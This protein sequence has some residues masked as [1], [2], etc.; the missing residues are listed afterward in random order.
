M[1]SKMK[2]E[3]IIKRVLFF[4][5]VLGA[6]LRIPNIFN[7]LPY[8][9]QIDEGIVNNIVLNLNISDLNPHDY[10]YPGLIYYILFPVFA[11]FKLFLLP[12]IMHV[13][14]MGEFSSY[15]LIGRALI[16]VFGISGII[17]IYAA[18]KEL[19][20]SYTGLIAALFLAIDPMCIAWS[21]ILKPDMLM[22]LLV[23]TAFL[24]ICRLYNAKNAGKT[25]YVLA[26][27]FIGLAVA[28]KYN[29][30]LI[31]VPF[32]AV[33][34]LKQE[35]RADFINKNLF[36]ALFFICFAFFLFNPFIVLDFSTFLKHIKSE[37]NTATWGFNLNPM[38]NRQG[39]VNYPL[40]LV[41]TLGSG[42]L[43]L[44]ICGLILSARRHSKKDILILSFPLIYY[45][46]IGKFKNSPAHYILPV[47]PFIL[48]LAAQFL[49][50]LI[51]AVNRIRQL[52]KI[53]R[54]VIFLFFLGI[55]LP[56]LH[57]SIYY[58]K[59]VNQ[60]DTRIMARDWMRSNISSR[61]RVLMDGFGNDSPFVFP[62]AIET[63]YNIEVIKWWK[64]TDYRESLGKNDFD[65]IIINCVKDRPE[66]IQPLYDFISRR[67][68]LIKE[69][70]PRIC[71]PASSFIYNPL[72][73][74]VIKVY[75][76]RKQ[77]IE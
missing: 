39:W 62:G 35:K 14:N 68:P 30:I 24:F 53:R 20:D 29:A 77:K 43:F 40:A 31:A 61:D 72:Y 63:P 2:E 21:F 33:H 26:G 47:I 51:D 60:E 41:S 7:G 56:T 76:G 74:P 8:F 32:A 6:I 71:K 38:A 52:E 45:I 48:L 66:D 13:S 4:I 5:I 50:I 44:S 18:G 57:N 11:F 25:D 70:E 17:I 27:L 16:A 64:K 34:F 49:K 69:F 10:I 19:F 15:V 46:V 73:H 36:L 23:L 55:I 58:I 12:H 1:V 22:S 67:F 42:V 54:G 3:K 9:I 59:W 75:D 37:I 28:A 65:F